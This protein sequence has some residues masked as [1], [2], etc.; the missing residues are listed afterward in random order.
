MF[1]EFESGQ[2]GFQALSDGE[3]LLPPDYGLFAALAGVRA[4]PGFLP[5]QAPRGIPRDVSQHVADRYFVP[6]LEDDRAGAWGIGEHFTPTHAAQLVEAGA[7][8]WL[9]AGTTVPLL[10]ATHGYIAHPDWHSAS[11]LT[12]GELTLALNHAR[13]Q[14]AAA[15]D[16]LQLLCQYV[17]AVAAKKGPSTRVVFWFD[18]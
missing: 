18:N 6:V 10:P 2:A 16:E 13:F 11:W 12:S 1:A 15:S 5:F 4:G 17:C 14:L 3:F 8:R 7:S 9:P